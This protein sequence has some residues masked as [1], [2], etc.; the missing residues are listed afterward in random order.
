V[1][2]LE[3]QGL[4]E[5]PLVDQVAQVGP[6]ELAVEPGEPG[7]EELGGHE[8]ELQGHQPADA[9]GRAGT[10]AAGRRHHG[11]DDELPHPGHA[12]RQEGQEGG[13]GQQ[14]HRAGPIRAPDEA[15]RAGHLPEDGP[16][17]GE[18][19]GAGLGRWGGALHFSRALL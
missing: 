4:L 15:Q 10:A 7:E 9:P 19:A 1:A 16:Q 13:Q 3:L 14:R 17:R 2:Q 11:V 6:Q 18:A 12:G 5:Q 8:S